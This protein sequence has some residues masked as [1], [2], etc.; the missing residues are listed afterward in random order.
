MDASN[1][2]FY[3][4]LT[5][6]LQSEGNLI[7]SPVLYNFDPVQVAAA[8]QNALAQPLSDGSPSP[9]SGQNA[10]SAEALLI[11]VIS[12]VQD[13]LGHEI[14][15]MP[16]LALL[17][18]LA[19]YGVDLQ[20]ATYPVLNL[21]F[22]LSST[23]I[24]KGT[25]ITIPMGTLIYSALDPSR[26]VVTLSDLTIT[27][28]LGVTGSVQARYSSTGTLPANYRVGEFSSLPYNLAPLLNSVYDDGTVVSAGSGTESASSVVQRSR[29]LIQTGGTNRVTTARDFY[30]T[31]IDVDGASQAN[32]LPG[33]TYVQDSQGND[34]YA[35]ADITTVAVYPSSVIANVDA[36]LSTRIGAGRAY[37]VLGA[38]IVPVS[39]SLTVQV[40]PSVPVPPAYYT[41]TGS[42]TP[43]Q[44]AGLP[45]SQMLTN[46]NTAGYSIPAIVNSIISTI[47]NQV[48]P[49]YGTW[50]DGEFQHTLQQALLTISGISSVPSFNLI[51][52]R[53]GIALSS[54]TPFFWHLFEV[55]NDII[56]NFTY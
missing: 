48:N 29:A 27:P 49:P 55:Q 3:Y 15:L 14:N 5:A 54:F 34:S 42:S 53:T 7:S 17:K 33:I 26:Y 50:G 40:Y 16:D 36:D 43:I 1:Y 8:A 9:F 45:L 21:V 2:Q 18:I 56:I 52:E 11:N 4:D 38:I 31:A 6:L 35:Y 28:S 13:L 22:Y 41:P 30:T 25:P 24:G 44:I 51:D 46:A 23:V 37:Q 19:L 10:F 32:I 20:P 47:I 12:H 39:G